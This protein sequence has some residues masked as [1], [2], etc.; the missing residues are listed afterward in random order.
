MRRAVPPVRGKLQ[1]HALSCM[2]L[3]HGR[4]ASRQRHVHRAAGDRHAGCTGAIAEQLRH[5]RPRAAPPARAHRR[6]SR[7]RCPAP[8]GCGAVPGPVSPPRIRAP[9][10]STVRPSSPFPVGDAD[11]LR[12]HLP[13]IRP[14]RSDLAGAR[15][16]FSSIMSSRD[17][18]GPK[19]TTT[20]SDCMRRSPASTVTAP[21]NRMTPANRS[22]SASTAAIRTT[23]EPPVPNCSSTTA[24]P[25]RCTSPRRRS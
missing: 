6:G 18:S 4:A 25:S 7:P 2:E 3:V 10:V 15:R 5:A 23:G 1:R 12:R 22:T 16:R 21:L 13:E 17:S 19:R 24:R 8:T 20:V 11:R 9:P 14:R